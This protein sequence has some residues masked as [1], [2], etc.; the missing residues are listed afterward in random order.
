MIIDAFRTALR[1]AIVEGVRVTK[2]GQMIDDSGSRV[3]PLEWR[4]EQ[5]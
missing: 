4:Y 2:R 1:G 3:G 5:Y